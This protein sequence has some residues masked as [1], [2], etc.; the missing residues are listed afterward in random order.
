[1]IIHN[2]VH[3]ALTNQPKRRIDRTLW[4]SDIGRNP[5]GALKRLLTG[6]MEP[7]DYPTLLKM[8]GGN[9][10][11]AFTLRQV[12]ENISRPVV[13]Q[14]PLFDDIWSGY[15]DLV[16]GHGSDDVIIYDHKGSAGQWWDY[17]ASLPRTADCLQ[18]WM[19]G[20]LYEAAY[21]V[22]PRLG[23]YYRGWGCWAEFEI[24]GILDDRLETS[25]LAIGNITDEKGKTVQMVDRERHV[26]PFWLRKNLEDGYGLVTNGKM[27][28]RE[29]ELM[30]PT[31][32][33]PDWD[34]AEG[35][36]NSQIIDDGGQ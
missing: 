29:I 10:L 33:R 26:N 13:T 5:Y 31:G 11:E 36:C 30:A 27:T 35:W 20:Q 32:G 16:I 28:L 34:W 12:A 7:F 18:V 2:A 3:Q 8:D 25:L 6:E 24:K 19:Y 17:K 21:G 14:F 4:V 22:T 1:M 9:A 15:A 23:L